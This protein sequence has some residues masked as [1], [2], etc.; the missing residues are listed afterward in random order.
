[1][2]I[3][4][5]TIRD[6][7]EHRLH[8]A[9]IEQ[10][11]HR[12]SEGERTQLFLR[13][14]EFVR[15]ASALIDIGNRV[16]DTLSLDVLF[17]RLMEVV[18]ETLNAERSS[19]FLYDADT[20]E[21][22]SRVM[23]DSVVGE[24]RFP[25]R[26][27]VAGAVFAS[28][29]SEIIRDAY[30]DARFNREIDEKTGYVTRNMLCVPI[31]N[32]AGDVIGITQALNKR[33]GA[34]DLEDQKL[35]E[36]LSLQASAALGNAQ[37]HESVER[38]QREEAL[39]LEVGSAIASE[40]HI[41][42]LLEMIVDAA[43]RL[44]DAERGSLFLYDP[45]QH[46]LYSRVAGGVVGGAIRIAIDSGLSGECFKRN[47][48]IS[49]ADTQTDPRF[50]PEV[51]RR[52]GF[53]TQNMLIV[54][55]TTKNGNKVGVIEVL[56]KR[57]GPFTQTD[58][59][60]L[61]ALGAQA[62]VSIENAMLFEQVS[63]ARSYN[64]DIL[65]SMSNG[66]LTLD[67]A[68]TILKANE[69]LSRI[70]RCPQTQLIGKSVDETLGSRNPWVSSAL[71]QVGSSGKTVIAM[72]TEL[73]L[74]HGP[75][76][77]V[78]ATAL[79]LRNA[80]N[81]PIGFL[82]VIEDVTREKRLRNTMS[83]YLSHAVVEKVLEN[84]GV[85]LDGVDREV[86]VLFSDIRGF[87]A[88]TEKLG[89]RE[90]VSMLNQYFDCMVDVVYAHN[91]I[92]DKFIGDMIMAVFGSVFPGEDDVD[93]AVAVG[94]KMMNALGELNARRV[95][96]NH[97]PIHIGVGIGTGRVIAGSIGSPRRLD[98]TVIGEKVNLAE[99][100]EAATKFYGV[101]ILVCDTTASRLRRSARLRE[102]DIVR[103]PGMNRPVTVYEVLD[104]HTEESFPRGDIV[105]AAFAEG[106]RQFRLRD[107]PR[108]AKSFQEA[109]AANPADQPSRI[110]LKRCERFGSRPPAR[111]WDGVANLESS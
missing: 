51:D 3:N 108:A 72:D 28:G 62:A 2:Q 82:L 4:S 74:D 40:I 48:P 88:M 70:L 39:L 6:I 5:D 13:V 68:G 94:T 64:E 29:T 18:S 52:T 1:M 15:R 19:L 65:R 61:V 21:L 33:G 22:F 89:A 84:E 57:R 54:P 11:L 36:A 31:K 107:W 35:L 80:H 86:S 34:F 56:N 76:V 73:V 66:V 25:C 63:E 30:A 77:S 91:G 101:G 32:K 100:L 42:P 46:E 95:A 37:L 97:A 75:A 53:R 44:L 27:G 9:D 92:L 20:E 24:V 85:M 58:A 110:Y 41:N 87:S 102:I 106:I 50:N 55:L 83:R 47:I 23:Q 90:T 98:Y 96:A 111:D 93:N 45:R 71:H 7:V 59:R 43:T 99:R 103:M 104:H 38:V 69:S 12:L 8:Q 16:Y 81:Q 49:I 14:T 105:L 67:T 78:N 17:P 79:S 26:L 10:L 60:R 109:L